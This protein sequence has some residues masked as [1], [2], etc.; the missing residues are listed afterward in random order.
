MNIFEELK[1]HIEEFKVAR[2]HM[3][4]CAILPPTDTG[5]NFGKPPFAVGDGCN[6]YAVIDKDGN[7]LPL[8]F[9]YQIPDECV[10]SEDVD[11][12]FS[13]PAAGIGS[14]FGIASYLPLV[15]DYEIPGE[16]AF[17]LETAEDSEVCEIVSQAVERLV[18]KVA[19]KAVFE[20]NQTLANAIVSLY[21]AYE[22]IESIDQAISVIALESSL[23]PTILFRSYQHALDSLEEEMSTEEDDDDE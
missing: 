14:G 17:C 15:E 6:D 13:H 11:A 9:G 22:E 23:M 16:R 21:G 12:G 2:D 4:S 10:Q 19:Q 5:R 8:P 1:P 20:F 7:V 18:A 3:M